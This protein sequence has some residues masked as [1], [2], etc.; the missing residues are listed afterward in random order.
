M[1]PGPCSWWA[2]CEPRTPTT[3]HIP[4]HFPSCLPRKPGFIKPWVPESVAEGGAHLPGLEVI[5]L[6]APAS[7]VEAVVHQV[8]LHD[9][10]LGVEEHVAGSA[11]GGLAHI[12]HCGQDRS[13]EPCTRPSRGVIPQP[14]PD[15][16]S[17]HC[18]W[19]P[20]HLPEHLLGA[21][22]APS[23]IMQARIY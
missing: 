13:E 21:S 1:S 7:P 6:Q 8:L 22:P 20:S 18:P 15:P 10:V 19:L 16:N 5:L 11:A 3:S 4:S 17:V 14:T 9:T 12:V 23:R 2:G